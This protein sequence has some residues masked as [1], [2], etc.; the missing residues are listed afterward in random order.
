MKSLLKLEEFAQFVLAIVLFNQ[1]PFAWWWFPALLLVPDLGMLGYLVNPKIGAYG[2]NLIHHKAFALAVGALG[3]GLNNPELQLT[4]VIL[5]G[6]A[7]MDRLFGYGLKF[8]DGFD[9]THLGY[10]GKKT[11]R[12]TDAKPQSGTHRA[13]SLSIS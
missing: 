1:L 6:H 4:G 7:A 12:P 13:S 3:F 2:Y 5:F 8:T 10:T 9:H 11:A